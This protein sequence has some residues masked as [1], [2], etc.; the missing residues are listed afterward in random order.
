[1]YKVRSTN[2]WLTHY[3]KQGFTV[4]PTS[5]TW[6]VGVMGIFNQWEA[7]AAGDD[8]IEHGYVWML[9][10]HWW[11][12]AADGLVK[13]QCKTVCMHFF[14]MRILFLSDAKHVEFFTKTK[15]T[16]DK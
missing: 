1:M 3:E 4:Y 5:R 11:K 16:V 7:L 8:V 14:G 6:F 2:N 15:G 10:N 13:K 12:M 9:K